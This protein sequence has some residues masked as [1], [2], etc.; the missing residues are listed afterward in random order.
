MRI[1]LIT[2]AATLI[3]SHPLAAYSADISGCVTKAGGLGPITSASVTLFDGS[4]N[5]LQDLGVV[6]STSG[7]YTASDIAEGIYHLQIAPVAPSPDQSYIVGYQQ[8]VVNSS[9]NVFDFTLELGG[10]ISGTVS[11]EAPINDPDNVVVQVFETN[12]SY[13]TWGWIDWANDG[14][15]TTEAV[16]SGEYLVKFADNDGQFQEEWYGNM[17][18]R[19]NVAWGVP[20]VTVTTNATTAG[21]DASLHEIADSANRYYYIDP[22][23]QTFYTARADKPLQTFTWMIGNIQRFSN[24]AVIAS[25]EVASFV[26]NKPTA[27]TCTGYPMRYDTWRL[28]FKD[29]NGDGLITDSNEYLGLNPYSEGGG[30]CQDASYVLE[31][32]QYQVVSTFK[33]GANNGEALTRTVTL[34]EPAFNSTSELPPP[35][36]LVSTW[37]KTTNELSLSWTMP[38]YGSERTSQMQIRVY[39]FKNGLDLDRQVRIDQL[40]TTPEM[41]H[42]TLT[43]DMTAPFNK[44]DIDQIMVQIRVYGANNHTVS[45][46]I[47]S[48][49]FDSEAGTLTPAE[50]RMTYF[51]V[52]GDGKTGLAETIHTLKVVSER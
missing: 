7:C 45:R 25:D 20:R 2:L 39:L 46:V 10:N 42:F 36:N 43:K 1:P 49:D 18:A 48:Y 47:E 44:S 23:L 19:W 41:N 34:Q 29:Q 21:I 9:N 51:D 28:R 31:A 40:P 13:V 38:T 33:N 32:G 22:Y 27:T 37:D 30:E 16:P 14:A 26:V 6:N 15:Y 35:T 5:L 52:N 12:G 3:F 4:N 50:I 8:I 24:D 17:P 11:L